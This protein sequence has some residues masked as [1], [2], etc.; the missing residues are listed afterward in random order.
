MRHRADERRLAGI[1]HAEQSHVGQHLQFELQVPT[2]ARGAVRRL[3]R[4]PVRAA[5]EARI[6]QPPAA[7]RRDHLALTVLG[8]I[9]DEFA[10][11][12]ILHHGAARHVYI[13]IVPGPAGLVP[14]RTALAALG[15]ELP[16]NPEIRQ[17]IHGGIGNE[18]HVAAVAA[19]AAVRA[20]PLDVFFP[21][22]TQAAVPAVSGLHANG[23][24][25]DEF[26]YGIVAL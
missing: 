1:R 17:G 18:V 2:L 21:P 24:F 6:A 11:V 10:R 7:A 9:A 25:V 22:K 26:H 20:A 12:D 23:C 8:E 3:A 15:A 19:V 16:R 14:A 4:G 5:L 13:E